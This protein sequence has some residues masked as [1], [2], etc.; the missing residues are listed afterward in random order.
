MLLR[1]RKMN[2]SEQTDPAHK[3]RSYE[4]SVEFKGVISVGTD[5]QTQNFKFPVILGEEA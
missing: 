3:D 4:L 5:D 1:I 2:D